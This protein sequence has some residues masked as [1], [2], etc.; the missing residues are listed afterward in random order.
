MSEDLPLAIG[1]VIAKR[2]RLEK[3]TMYSSPLVVRNGMKFLRVSFCGLI[4]LGVRN[5]N[6]DDKRGNNF[7][8]PR[9]THHVLRVMPHPSPCFLLD[10]VYRTVRVTADL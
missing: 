1:P 2:S 7:H 8:A 6:L 9:N 3:S 5:W 10:T 4:L